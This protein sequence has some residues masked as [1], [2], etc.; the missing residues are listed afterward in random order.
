MLLAQFITP[1]VLE[2]PERSSIVSNHDDSEGYPGSRSGIE[3]VMASR[4][5]A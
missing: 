5:Y 4:R 1:K 2:T 3:D